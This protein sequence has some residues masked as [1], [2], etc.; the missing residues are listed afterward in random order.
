MNVNLSITGINNQNLLSLTGN[1]GSN[2]IE[3]IYI[4]KIKERIFNLYILPLQ[5]NNW[6]V[7]NENMFAFNDIYQKLQKYIK[8]NTVSDLTMYFTIIQTIR[9][10]NGEYNKF[11][12]DNKENFNGLAKLKQYLPTIRLA[13]AYELYNLTLGIPLN[14]KYD[15]FIIS[16]INRLLMDE[17]ITFSEIK[18]FILKISNN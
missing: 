6:K 12:E 16:H 14:N 7:I 11:N 4:K 5:I 15:D 9:E 10:L 17:N 13:P 3:P 1:H 18:N 2:R 8:I